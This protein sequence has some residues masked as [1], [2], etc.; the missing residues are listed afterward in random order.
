MW[1]LVLSRMY[2]CS[3]IAARRTLSLAIVTELAPDSR[4]A[5]E[6]RSQGGQ[7]DGQQPRRACFGTKISDE[8]KDIYRNETEPKI[9]TDARNKGGLDL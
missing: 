7:W 3:L 8:L 1:R 4:G 9:G 5:Y 6:I 2:G